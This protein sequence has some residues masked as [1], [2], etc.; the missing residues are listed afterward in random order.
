[1]IKDCT[2]I[3]NSAIGGT[4]GNGN[5]TG[6]RG[7]GG[8]GQGGAVYIGENTVLVAERS[9][10]GNN[11]AFGGVRG[12]GSNTTDSNPADGQGGAIYDAGVTVMYDCILENN[13]AHGGEG[14]D[15][16]GLV[17]APGQGG[18]FF[19]AGGFAA[20]TRCTVISNQAEGGTGGIGGSTSR[21]EGGGLF[22]RYSGNQFTMNVNNCTV[23]L[24]TAVRGNANGDASGGGIWTED[25]LNLINSTVAFNMVYSDASGA[26]GG[27]RINGGTTSLHNT[28]V[29]ENI[30]GDARTQISRSLDS[31]YAAWSSASFQRIGAVGEALDGED[32][33]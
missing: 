18:G 4:G 25:M 7:R 2:F 19:F 22:I 16:T 31:M 26:G 12:A 9:T 1:M 3:N 24:N 6:T 33:Q 15:A 11:L 8:P 21:G 23:A 29:A 20:L 14:I 13:D 32:L 5:G 30:L 10:F 28:L 27:M 17:G